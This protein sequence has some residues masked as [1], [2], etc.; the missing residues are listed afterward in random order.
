MN[1][2]RYFFKCLSLH[3]QFALQ[4]FTFKIILQHFLLQDKFIPGLLMQGNDI[5]NKKN[6][7]I[8]MKI[9]NTITTV[10]IISLD[11]DTLT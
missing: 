1:F 11:I 8:I 2:H 4:N 3:L 9:T 10:A 6:N 7:S 5:Y